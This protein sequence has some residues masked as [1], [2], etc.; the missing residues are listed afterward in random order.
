IVTAPNVDAY[1]WELKNFTSG[2]LS[3]EQRSYYNSN[4][5]IKNN[6][7]T[8]LISK[9]F[10]I[11]SVLDSK[12]AIN[13][14]MALSLDYKTFNWAFKNSNTILE[15][16]SLYLTKNGNSSQAIAFALEGL[17]VTKDGG[18]VDFGNEIIKGPSFIGTKADCVLKELISAGNNLF[19][20]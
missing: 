7:N 3:R 6:I 13:V 12:L 11:F 15:R 10:S 5:N 14:G 20:K 9:N 2:E 16:A 17:L 19:K 18:D 1:L 8:Y 4:G